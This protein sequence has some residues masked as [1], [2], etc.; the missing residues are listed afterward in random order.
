LVFP[1]DKSHNRIIAAQ[2]R[3][4]RERVV[5][6]SEIEAALANW[7][8]QA[9]SPDGRLPEDTDPAVWI[10]AQFS[11][12]WRD[13]AANSLGEAELVARQARDELI[14]LGGWGPF[15]AALHELAHVSDALGELRSTLGLTE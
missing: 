6:A 3:R 12:W 5:A 8:R 7:L 2:C 9:T 4:V 10:A 14:R 13:R 11:K 1:G 15:G